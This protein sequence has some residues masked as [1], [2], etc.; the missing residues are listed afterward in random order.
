MRRCG[1]DFEPSRRARSIGIK[2]GNNFEIDQVAIVQGAMLHGQ[3]Q[4]R[5]AGVDA[6]FL[7]VVRQHLRG[8]SC[9]GGLM[10]FETVRVVM[11][12]AAGTNCGFM[13]RV[14]W[15]DARSSAT[16]ILSSPAKLSRR[17]RASAAAF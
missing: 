13:P 4:F 3:Q 10:N 6:R 15:F 8:F 16:L 1:S 14:P 5:P 11:R 17:A 12:L 2:A 7:A 9:A